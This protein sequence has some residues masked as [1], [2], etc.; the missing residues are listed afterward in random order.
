MRYRIKEGIDINTYEYGSG[1]ERNGVR[2]EFYP[3]GHVLGSAQ[4]LITDGQERWVITGDYKVENDGISGRFAPI[5]CDHFVTETTFALPVF[6]WRPQVQVFEEINEWWRGN[7]AEGIL[8][9]IYAYSLGKA[10]RVLSGLDDAIGPIYCHYTVAD[11]NEIYLRHG[12]SF[13]N[14]ERL[15]GRSPKSI[16]GSGIIVAPPGIADSK[17]ISGIKKKEEAMASGWMALRGIR[18]RRSYDRGFVL[19]DHVDWKA[20]N[21]TVVAT[22]ASHVYPV[23]GYTEIYARYLRENGLKAID[24]KLNIERSE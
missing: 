3:A 10:Q 17:M 2:F 8:T 5:L 22:G 11:I 6:N 24:F 15:D 1:F 9:V 23:H 20:L 21:E 13:P 7:A 14:W 16:D 18:R 4:V 12:V 19:S